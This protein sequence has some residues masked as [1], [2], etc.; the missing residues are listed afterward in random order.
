MMCFLCWGSLL[1]II[2]LLRVCKLMWYVYQLGTGI[3][4]YDVRQ[5]QLVLTALAE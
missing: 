3:Q 4:R 1:T 2:S 5:H